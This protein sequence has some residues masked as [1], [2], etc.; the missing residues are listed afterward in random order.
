MASSIHMHVRTRLEENNITKE[1]VSQRYLHYGVSQRRQWKTYVTCRPLFDAFV[2]LFFTSIPSYWWPTASGIYTSR[3]STVA[4]SFCPPL[5]N[6]RRRQ[7]TLYDPTNLPV[8][9]LGQ[10]Q[11][12]RTSWFQVYLKLSLFTL[13]RFWPLLLSFSHSLLIWLL[14]SSSMIK[15]HSSLWSHRRHWHRVIPTH[16]RVWMVP[17]FSWVY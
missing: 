16:P 9:F 12:F 4:L 1:S 6:F 11:H 14:L 5:S 10:A 3:L 17:A 7:P 15:L 8:F 13:R 2:T